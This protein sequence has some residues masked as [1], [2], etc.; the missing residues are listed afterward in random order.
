MS[1]E[2][3]AED[4]GADGD[5][6]EGRGETLAIVVDFAGDPVELAGGFGVCGDGYREDHGAGVHSGWGFDGDGKLGV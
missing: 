6:D 1:G 3:G 4:V 5:G 2:G